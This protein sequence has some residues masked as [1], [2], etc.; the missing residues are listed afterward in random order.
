MTA[1]K[2]LRVRI[3]HKSSF[4]VEII[5]DLRRKA[6]T[7]TVKGFGESVPNYSRLPFKETAILENHSSV[8]F[9]NY[10]DIGTLDDN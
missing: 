6:D 2:Y 10:L 5:S 4:S 3:N 8:T 1:G 7:Y 9:N